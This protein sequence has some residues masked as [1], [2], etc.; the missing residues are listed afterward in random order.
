MTALAYTLTGRNVYHMQGPR[1]FII[2]GLLL[3]GIG[4]FFV[5]PADFIGKP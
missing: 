1:Y 5:G 3:F 4:Y 2:S